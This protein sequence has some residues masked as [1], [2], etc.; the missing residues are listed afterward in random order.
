MDGGN[1]TMSERKVTLIP[2][3]EHFITQGSSAPKLYRVRVAAYARVS[4]DTEEQANSYEAQVDYYTNHI[5]NNPQWEYVDVYADQD[6][7]GTST[8]GREGFNR[9][10]ADALDGKIDLILVKSVSRFA[11]NTVD[12]LET[13]RK[14]KER[15]IEVFFEKENIRTLDSKGEVLLT[16]LSSLAQDE[17]RNISENVTWG[18]RKRFADGKLIIPYTNFLGYQK[19]KDGNPE[20]VPKEAET[21]RRIYKCFLEGQSLKGIASML[22]QEGVETPCGG[23]KWHANSV[24]SI[25]QSEKYMGAALLQ[26][27]YT[28]DFLTKRQIA[29]NGA[30]AQYYV[31]NSHP[32]IV[33]KEIYQLVQA[34]FK[35]RENNK[36]VSY[37]DRELSGKIVCGECGGVYGSKVWHST[38]KY[39]RVVWQCNGKYKNKGKKACS[40]PH[41]KEETV[42]QAFVEVYNGMVEDKERFISTLEQSI[43]ENTKSDSIT[44]ALIKAEEQLIITKQKIQK[45]IADNSHIAMDQVEYGRAFDK[46]CEKSQKTEAEIQKL[47]DEKLL[48]DT[49]FLQREYFIRQLKKHD[50][51]ILEFDI[52]LFNVIVETAIVKDSHTL[53]FAFRDGTKQDWKY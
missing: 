52:D 4:T 46:L 6:R 47:K 37:G 38:D 17:S 19:G 10:I 39:R 35:R 48:M 13:V 22:T 16:I 51:V 2:A 33:S 50:K 28:I 49:R 14:L 11:R 41:I 34:E 21:V 9:M 1:E 27:T 20:I 53:T 24:K 32:P 43:A 23:E 36:G 25:L 8:K 45:L 26:K 29:N 7:T 15:G 31:E 5:Q 3:K 18:I 42:K 12:T 40:V 44:E 30:V